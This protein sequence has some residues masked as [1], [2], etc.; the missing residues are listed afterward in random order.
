MWY[1]GPYPAL[2]LPCYVVSRNIHAKAIYG[3]TGAPKGRFDL[4]IADVRFVFGA[5][6]AHAGATHKSGTA[7]AQIRHAILMPIGSILVTFG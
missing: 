3:A 7:G 6:K 1:G 2:L 5:P 4:C